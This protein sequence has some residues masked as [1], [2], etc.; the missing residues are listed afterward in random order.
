ME[1]SSH[2]RSDLGYIGIYI[3][4]LTVNEGGKSDLSFDVN[5]SVEPTNHV[6][7]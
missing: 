7:T 5:P 2:S 1:T 3:Y 4:T 6:Q